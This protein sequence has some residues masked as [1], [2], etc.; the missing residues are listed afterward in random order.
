VRFLSAPYE[1]D[2]LDRLT[3]WHII[4]AGS[5]MCDAGRIRKHLKRLLWKRETTVLM[6]GFQAAG[7]LGRLLADGRERVRIQGDEI[8]VRARVRPLDVYS[9]HADA[10]GLV[11]WA[12]ARQ[13]IGGSVFLAHGEPGAVMGL[14]RRLG[15]A[16]LALDRVLTP[17]LDQG[18]ILRPTVV[19]AQTRPG[20]LAAGSATALDWHNQRAAFLSALDQR[21]ERASDDQ[22]REALLAA[23]EAAVSG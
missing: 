1:S 5:G 2:S 13:P 3:G 10:T 21:L 9:S 7:S 19:E 16:G 23:L 12:M 20:R 8:R 14:K 6:T 4:M 22:E 15:G 18:Y 17:E 11:A